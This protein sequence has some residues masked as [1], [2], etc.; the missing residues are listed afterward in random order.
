[1]KL[2]H[3]ARLAG[4]LFICGVARADLI[5]DVNGRRP[6]MTQVILS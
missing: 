1:M 2:M 6:S 4:L 5:I 3:A